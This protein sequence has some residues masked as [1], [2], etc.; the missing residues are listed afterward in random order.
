MD[1]KVR[2]IR[3]NDAATGEETDSIVRYMGSSVITE[4]IGKGQYVEAFVHTQLAVERILWERINRIFEG[5]RATQT[6]NRIE[7]RRKNRSFARTHELI[8]WAFILG[9]INDAEHGLLVD[10]N[11]KRNSILHAH[12]QWWR[13]TEYLQTLEKAV[14][15][16]E[17]N[18][19]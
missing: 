4:M 17:R 5:E 2:P 7:S 3:V 10:F 11:S 9:V 18:S 12:G 8:E 14:H 16:L 13:K 6:R 19:F 15:F 1:P